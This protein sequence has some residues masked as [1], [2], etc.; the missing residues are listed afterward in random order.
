MDR[1]IDFF[2]AL[3]SLASVAIAAVALFVKG[4]TKDTIQA[5]LAVLALAAFLIAYMRFRRFA[6]RPTSRIPKEQLIKVA[7]GHILSAQSKVVLFSNDLSWVHDYA[8]ALRDRVSDGKQVVVIHKKSSE[9]RVVANSNFL[10]NIGAQVIELQE[11]HEIRA[12][13]VD[14]DDSDTALLFAASKRRQAGSA[15]PVQAGES[16]TDQNYIY[17]CAVYQGGAHKAVVR[18]IARLARHGYPAK[19]A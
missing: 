12:T 7:R 10:K 2:G 3:A 6:V 19:A 1:G 9:P 14:P 15:A 13:L 8:D 18:A 11:D 17:E 4:D 16:G 5:V